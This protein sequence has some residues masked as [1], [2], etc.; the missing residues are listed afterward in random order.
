LVR[1]VDSP[2]TFSPDGKRF[3][4]LRA[5]HDTPN[6]DLLI[7]NA[8]GSPNKALF[9]NRPIA[10]DSSVPAWSP[11][12]TT[13]VIPIDQPT[14]DALGGLLSVDV[15]TGKTKDVAIT[16]DRI[17]FDP[18][19]LPNG[20]GLVVSSALAETGL[21]R[22]QLG[23]LNYPGGA[24][25]LLTT[26]T[27]N[28]LH[29]SV[30]MDGHSLAVNQTQLQYELDVASMATPDTISAVPLTSHVPIWRWDWAADG[31]LVIPQA[32]D[33]RLV[34]ATGGENVVFSDA[35]HLSVDAVSCGGGQYIVFRSVGR[36]R[37]AAVNLWR[38]D[39]TGGNEK[40]LTYGSNDVDPQCSKDGKWVYYLDA[41]DGNAIKRIPV[42]GGSPQTA[43]DSVEGPW[44]LSPDGK[45]IAS[46]DIRELDHQLVL[47]LYSIDDKKTTYQDVDQRASGPLSFSPDG[48][49]MVYVVQQKGV[50]N[51]WMQPLGGSA[52]TRPLT[53]FATERISRFVFSQDGSKIAIQRGHLESDAVL[54]TDTPK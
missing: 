3:A 19:W 26:D 13:I 53:H 54:I 1:D 33:I 5:H 23:F 20:G 8:D 43:L 46:L 29:P 42:A 44:V 2:I 7:A 47:N 21:S 14:H 27:N 39:A 15:N 38:M 9:T 49:A 52:A 25:R 11:D 50:D 32:G 34:G 45:T 30:A 36:A 22:R 35:K 12:G 51:L 16:A 18:A 24:F 10:T 41:P 48:K 4:Y 40:Q 37:A 6:F 17:Y 31:R 28:Y